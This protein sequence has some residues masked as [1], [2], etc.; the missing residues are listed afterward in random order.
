MRV[1]SDQLKRKG[2]WAPTL[3]NILPLSSSG[4]GNTV[5]FVLPSGPTLIR[6]LPNTSIKISAIISCCGTLQCISAEIII[7]QGD[8]TN[9]YLMI[10]RQTSRRETLDV[11][12]LP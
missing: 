10:A 3:N 11:K 9:P 2:E 4:L 8:T 12:D 7:G 5:T 1:S 6:A